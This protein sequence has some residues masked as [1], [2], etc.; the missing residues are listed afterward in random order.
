MRLVGLLVC[1]IFGASLV[2]VS[3]CD[4]S[5]CNAPAHTTYDCAP[6]STDVGG[7]Q[8][9]PP[10]NGTTYDPDK[11]FPLNCQASLPFCGS[12]YPDDVQTCNCQKSDFV[13]GGA[14]WA[15]PM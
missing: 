2:L 5:K 15:C 14:G 7:C 10:F 1:L 8:G 13:D 12:H 11:H 3:A 4:M 9:G 6:S